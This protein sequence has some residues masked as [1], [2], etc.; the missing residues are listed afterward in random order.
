[1]KKRLIQII[2][3]SLF[4]VIVS[5]SSSQGSTYIIEVSDFQFS[6]DT[7]N[8]L[9]GDTVK[10]VWVSGNH[11]T[12]SNGV[13]AGAEVWSVLIDSF[14]T[15]FTYIIKAAGVYHYISVPDLPAMTGEFTA[16]WPVGISSPSNISEL[17]VTPTIVDNYVSIKF[18]VLESGRVYIDLYDLQGKQQQT[19]FASELFPGEFNRSF[20]LP[21]RS[22]GLYLLIIQCG[23]KNLSKKIIIR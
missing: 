7:G 11:T 18:Q 14:H 4:I 8:Y 1:M 15:S 2:T 20:Y 10:W 22:A 5:T 16:T 21:R 23:S 17:I 13:P 9:V 19:L 6:P 3:Y 12:T